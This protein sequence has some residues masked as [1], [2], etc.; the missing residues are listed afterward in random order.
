MLLLQAKLYLFAFYRLFGIGCISAT[1]I[2]LFAQTSFW[3]DLCCQFVYQLIE[4]SA[5]ILLLGLSKTIRASGRTNKF[6]ALANGLALLVNLWQLQAVQTISKEAASSDKAGGQIKV[7]QCN[8]NNLNYAKDKIIST[9]NCGADILCLQ[10]IAPFTNDLLS[11]KE[12]KEAYPYRLLLIRSD[13]FGV[14]I[15]SRYPLKDCQMHK[16][17]QETV[18]IEATVVKDGQSIKVFSVHTL[19]PVLDDY[20]RCRNNEIA[21]LAAGAANSK[22]PVLVLG[23]FNC[24]SWSPHM[25][26][27]FAAQLKEVTA[28]PKYAPQSWHVKLPPPFR[29]PLDHIFVSK[30]FTVENFA[31]GSESGSDH[32]P[33]VATLKLSR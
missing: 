4:V 14:G 22:D 5:F 26:P 32:R 23:D 18:S 20:F 31:F 25:K 1:L 8:I 27:I 2:G 33:M 13:S 11:Q 10:E 29:L 7:M 17:E 9:L 12:L 28:L 30:H 21:Q 3:C 19:P 24:A 16:T 15:L 6:I